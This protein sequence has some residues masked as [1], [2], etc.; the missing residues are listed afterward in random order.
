MSIKLKDLLTPYASAM[1]E[2]DAALFIGAGMSRPAG[3]VDWKGLLAKC[4]LE[5]GLDV[6]REDDLVEV[7][8]FYLNSRRDRSA[9]N[10]ALIDE[11]SKPGVCPD[12][13]QI[14]A[15]LPVSTIWTT[16]CDVLIEEALREKSKRVDVKSRDGDIAWRKP[17]RAAVLYKMHGDIGHPQEVVICKDDYEDY[18][19]TH[20][21]FQN[22]LEGDLL[23]K[24]FLFLGFSFKDPN[25]G[26]ML[27]YLRSLLRE[28]KRA[29]YAVMR[30]VRLDWDVVSEKAH[31]DFEYKT[32]KQH[33]QIENLQ[34]YSIYTHLVDRYKDITEVLKALEH[35]YAQ[36]IIYLWVREGDN[37]AVNLAQLGRRL[38]ERLLNDQYKICCEFHTRLGRAV[39]AGAKSKIDEKHLYPLDRYLLRPMPTIKR[40]PE[41]SRSE[42]A[43][44]SRKEMIGKSGF[45]VFLGGCESDCAEIAEDFKLAEKSNTVS[46]PVG[47]SGSAA[48]TLW[49]QIRPNTD[50]VYGKTVSPETFDQLNR[51]DV[52]KLIDVI[53]DIIRKASSTEPALAPRSQLSQSDRRLVYENLREYS[54]KE[55]SILTDK[56]L[57]RIVGDL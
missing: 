16:N 29:H 57:R 50:R 49:D 12:Y 43:S 30:R 31:D 34:R 39:F 42:F 33:H 53:L 44:D 10:Q 7:A 19:R 45:A 13:H 41:P 14:L 25:L 17:G 47:S 2:G 3:F 4:A 37:K 46:I 6:N 8:Q 48:R 22:A 1:H 23:N 20:P 9:L 54:K 24:T 5:I 26:Q 40:E 52:D 55:F 56:D 36:K 28:S 15:R 35:E 21:I 51:N 18:P 32:V 27:G 38:G 11:F